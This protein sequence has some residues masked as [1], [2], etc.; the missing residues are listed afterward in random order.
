MQLLGTRT[1]TEILTEARKK[2]LYLIGATQS[3]SYFNEK[4]KNQLVVNTGVQLIGNTHPKD[5][6]LLTRYWELSKNQMSHLKRHQFVLKYEEQPPVTIKAPKR[7]N[8]KRF[9]I[10]T[11]QLAKLKQQCVY[12]SYY[13]KKLEKD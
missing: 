2:K 8:R 4:L 7:L 11:A 5:V 13:R 1:I 12:S 9:Q 10:H 3:L 6:Q